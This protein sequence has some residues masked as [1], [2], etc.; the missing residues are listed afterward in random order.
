MRFMRHSQKMSCL[1]SSMIIG[2]SG[3]SI[4]GNSY[5]NQPPIVY[6][7]NLQGRHRNERGMKGF[8]EVEL[9]KTSASLHFIP[10]S[11][12]VFDTTGSI[13]W[14]NSSCE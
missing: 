12:I 6:P 2:R 9:S 5:M 11:A 3:I 13:L 1:R 10:A 8:Y 4:C 14:R 7:G